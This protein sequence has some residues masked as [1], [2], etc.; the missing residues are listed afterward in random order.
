M[1]VSHGLHSKAAIVLPLLL[2]EDVL[3]PASLTPASKVHPLRVICL[4]SA[5]LRFNLTAL[6][7]H[8]WQL[9]MLASGAVL[10]S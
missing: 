9:R 1:G 2:R 3:D 5:A 6:T 7:A 4:P 10:L 8:S